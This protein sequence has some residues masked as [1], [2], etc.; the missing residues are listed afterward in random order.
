MVTRL[1]FC[2]L[3]NGGGLAAAVALWIEWESSL[4]T[5][6]KYCKKINN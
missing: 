1:V 6:L 3:S 2:T 5:T 4:Y